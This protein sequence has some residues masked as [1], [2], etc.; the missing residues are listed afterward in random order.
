MG[1]VVCSLYPILR[2]NP[3]AKLVSDPWFCAAVTSQVGLCAHFIHQFSAGLAALGV[4]APCAVLGAEG[5]AGRPGGLRGSAHT[6][7]ARPSSTG[8]YLPFPWVRAL[9]TATFRFCARYFSWF[10][11]NL[12]ASVGIDCC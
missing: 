6:W 9:Q 1:W 4:L 12:M 5:R 7:R 8:W 10:I 2:E 11:N 3:V